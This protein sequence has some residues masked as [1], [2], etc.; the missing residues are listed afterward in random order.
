MKRLTLLVLALIGSLSVSAQEKSETQMITE[1]WHSGR[2]LPVEVGRKY[3]PL[4]I[5]GLE[6]DNG[7]NVLIDIAHQCSFAY[8]WGLPDVL[9]PMGYRTVSSQASLNTVLDEKGK[10]RLRIPFDPANK[11]FP[12]AWY[13]NFKYNVVIT[14]QGDP[15]SPAYTEAECA[16]LVNFVKKGGSLYVLASPQRKAGVVADWSVNLLASKLGA[17]FTDKTDK[18]G[19]TKYIALKPTAKEWQVSVKGEAGEPIEMRR[20]LGKGRVVMSGSLDDL[21]VEQPR[22]VDSDSLRTEIIKRAAAKSKTIGKT[23]AWLTADQKPVGGEPRL[24]QTMGGGGAIYPELESGDNGIVVYYAPNVSEKLLHCVKTEIPKITSQILEW[25]PSDATD[26][27]MYLIL[28][29]GGGGG[30]AVNAFKPKENGIISL[31]EFGLMSIYAHE[32]AHTLGGPSN[33]NKVKAG[34]SPFHNQG[35]AHAGWF[36]GK[37]DAIYDPELAKQAVK[38]CQKY[39]AN[40]EFRDLD[41]KRY[42]QDETYAAK[43]GK[44]KDWHK[45]WYTWQRLDD[46][47]GKE[48]YPRW[49]QIQYER[50]A[51]DPKRNLTW[52]ESVEDMSLAVGADLFPFFVALNTGLDRYLMGE[53]EY[54]GKKVSLPVADIPITAPGTV[55]L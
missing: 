31:D 50:W 14:Q 2:T 5:D 6:N 48:W 3:P 34:E 45:I 10:S 4:V 11:I 22:R 15:A 23:M 29:A 9:L 38:S 54:Q 21:T 8:M 13:P 46:T 19:S 16:A 39:F 53:V 35:E 40:P 47:Y 25:L 41:I 42:A 12:F 27:P 17:V 28:S 55:K 43:F 1:A 18:V 30:W 49:K 26:E 20:T 36:Q 52:E 44:G 24:P 33:A 51:N 32:L 7:Y 37:I